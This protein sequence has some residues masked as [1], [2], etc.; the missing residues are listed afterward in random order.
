MKQIVVVG[1]IYIYITMHIEGDATTFITT[2]M[3][4]HPMGLVIW[5]VGQLDFVTIIYIGIYLVLGILLY[6]V[7]SRWRGNH[8]LFS[9]L[10]AQQLPVASIT[11]T[12]S[13]GMI[14]ISYRKWMTYYSTSHL[15]LLSILTRS[16]SS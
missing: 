9:I 8:S 5:S 12:S 1:N 6:V 2:T 11:T 4:T 10:L 14:G 13:V 7:A 15:T 16:H 3:V